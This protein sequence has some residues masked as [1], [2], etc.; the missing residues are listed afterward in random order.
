MTKRLNIVLPEQTIR[1]LNR[2]A[3]RGN[4][5]RLISDTVMYHV[6]EVQEQPGRTAQAGR[7]R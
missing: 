2:V 6:T 5:S 4:R 3:P 7:A 1:V